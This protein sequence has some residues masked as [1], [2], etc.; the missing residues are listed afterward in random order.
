MTSRLHGEGEGV[1]AII[2]R[3]EEYLVPILS[4]SFPFERL[5]D[6]LE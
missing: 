5:Q 3:V 2:T 1:L 4:G 6:L